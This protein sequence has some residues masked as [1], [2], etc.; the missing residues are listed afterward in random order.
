M[1]PLMVAA[2]HG[3]TEI[4]KFLILHEVDV[5]FEDRSG[6]IAVDYIK[7]APRAFQSLSEATMVGIILI[8]TCITSIL[9][10]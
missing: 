10:I 3:H 4:I 7:N 9:L 2:Q 6:K 5:L 8:Q 1:T